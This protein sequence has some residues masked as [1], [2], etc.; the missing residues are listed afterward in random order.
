MPQKREV[1]SL[2]KDFRTTW[3]DDLAI[4]VAILDKDAKFVYVNQEIV[5]L[6]GRSRKDILHTPADQFIPPADSGRMIREL[7]EIYRGVQPEKMVFEFLRP[8]GSAEKIAFASTPIYGPQRKSGR[9]VRYIL[10][11][12]VEK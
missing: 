4:G 2:E 6:F 3:F 8:N 1:G 10:A 5:R 7:L 11:V 12:Q 9:A